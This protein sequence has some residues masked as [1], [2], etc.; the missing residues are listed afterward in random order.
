M[1]LNDINDKSLMKKKLNR[2]AFTLI[3]LLVVIAIIGILAAM[4]MPALSKAKRKAQQT[5]CL[6]NERQIGLAFPLFAGDHDDQIPWTMGRDADIGQD[7]YWGQDIYPYLVGQ[8]KYQANGMP[9]LTTFMG[10]YLCPA[11][12][13]LFQGDMY[14]VTAAGRFLCSYAA[15]TTYQG[16]GT[17]VDYGV[18]SSQSV[19][20]KIPG[21]TGRRKTTQISSPCDAAVMTELATQVNVQYGWYGAFSPFAQTAA[22]NDGQYGTTT[23]YTLT[24]H[25]GI[26][27]Y[28][29]LDG[30]VEPLKWNDPRV[31]GTGTTNAAKGIWTITPND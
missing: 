29:F 16:A 11:H 31:I 12:S 19:M 5:A 9:N 8:A 28:V 10:A 25:G 2:H 7:T 26:V 14:N 13:A 6:S 30:H 1:N 24:V 3:E 18:S 20:I 27:N 15:P 23:N 17:G 4:L 21:Y 22:N